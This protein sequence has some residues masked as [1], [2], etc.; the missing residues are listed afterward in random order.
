MWCSPVQQVGRLKR[1]GQTEGLLMLQ[2]A[3]E[4]REP[5]KSTRNT[6]RHEG[7]CL[8]K[9][10]FLML[11]VS[12][13]GC[14]LIWVLKKQSEIHCRAIFT[15]KTCTTTAKLIGLWGNTTYLKS[16]QPLVICY[17]PSICSSSLS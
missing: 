3:S 16:H 15:H 5:G 13:D 11:S 9:E 4:E 7:N 6:S 8:P 10:Y 2:A 1:G 14:L 12:P 17:S